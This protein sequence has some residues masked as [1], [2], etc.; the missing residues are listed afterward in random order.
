MAW[1]T[2][3]QVGVLLQTD[4]SADAYIDALIDHAEGLAE[5]VIGS[6]TDP[7]GAGLQAVLATIVAR[8][9]QAGRNAQSNPAGHSMEQ[10]G[11]FAQQSP[12]A[13]AAGLGLTNREIKSLRKAAGLLS[14]GILPTTRGPLETPAVV[15][16]YGTTDPTVET[17]AGLAD[18]WEGGI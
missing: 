13:G 16:N 6:Q 5:A 4:L 8:M 17:W 9:W 1:I 11:P 15:D 7:V 3:D 12:N 10:T 14:V 18:T 2:S